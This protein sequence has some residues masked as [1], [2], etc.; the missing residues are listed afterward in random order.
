MKGNA[1]KVGFFSDVGNKKAIS[2]T[3]LFAVFFVDP[4]LNFHYF[5]KKTHKWDAL[6][7]YE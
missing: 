6:A 7:T 5:K 3:L 1:G 2:L 4:F